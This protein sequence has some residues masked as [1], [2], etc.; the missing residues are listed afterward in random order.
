VLS[1]VAMVLRTDHWWGAMATGLAGIPERRGYD[2]PESRPFLT[3]RLPLPPR[4]HVVRSALRVAVGACAAERAIPG[5]PPTSFAVVDAHR[6][7]ARGESGLVDPAP[8]VL[9]HPGASTPG[10]RWPPERWGSVVDALVGDG[11]PVVLVGGPGES[12]E[13]ARIASASRRRLHAIDGAPGLGELAALLAGARM[14]LGVDSA[15]MHLATAVGTPTLRLYGPGDEVLYG[16][17]GDPIRHRAMRA[18][19]SAPDPDWFGRGGGP[20]PTMVAL[21]AEPVIAAVRALSET[22]G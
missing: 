22:I 19:G 13:V 1:D 9:I 20:H 5:E 14:A 4:E 10:K 8:Y 15:P 2:V 18:A 16:P 3:A 6:A 17:W 12:A 11:W 21:A 7:A